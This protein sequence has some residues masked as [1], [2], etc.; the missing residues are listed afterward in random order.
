M[1]V[2]AVA[3]QPTA[4]AALPAV[5]PLPSPSASVSGSPTAI[6][7]AKPLPL[8]LGPPAPTVGPKPLPT[9]TPSI[10]PLP[11]PLPPERPT[12]L[13]AKPGTFTKAAPTYKITFAARWCPTYEDIRANK[14][15]NNIMESLQNLGPDTNYTS[16]EAVSV[17]KED[18]AP[19]SACTP[20]ADWLFQFGDGINGKTPGTNLSRVSNPGQTAST[21]SGV[22]E[23]DAMGNAT[24]RTIAGAVTVTLTQEQV[25]QANNHTLWIQGGTSGDP[26]GQ[27]TFP[28]QFG[29]GALRCAND[30]VNG[31]NVEFVSFTSSQRHVFCYYYS[32]KPPPAAGIIVIKKALSGI[33][34]SDVTFN[35][36]GNTSYNP[37]GAFSLKGGQSVEFVR[38]ATADTGFRWRVTEDIPADWRLAITCVSQGASRTELVGNNGVDIALVAGDKVTCTFTNAPNP[39]PNTLELG[40]FADGADGTFDYRVTSPSNTTI[41]SGRVSVR[42]G[43]ITRIG[44]YNITTTGT[45]KV[46]ET[47]PTSSNGTWA[48]TQVRCQ[49]ATG[50]VVN[51]TTASITVSALGARSGSYCVL[52]NTFT[53]NYGS[54]IIRSKTT[55]GAGG[56]TQYQI[57]DAAVDPGAVPTS[58]HQKANNVVAEV[59][60][61]AVPVTAADA[62]TRL[63]PGAYQIQGLG[64]AATGDASWSLSGLDCTG[65]ATSGLN[66]AEG[67]VTITVPARGN[68]VCDFTWAKAIPATLTLGK[69]EVLSGGARTSDVVIVAEC[70]NSAQA[71][72]TVTPSQAL[73]AFLPTPMTFTQNTRCVVRETSQG[74]NPADTTWQV[75]TP[76]GTLTGSGTTAVVSIKQAD[77]PGGAYQVVF[78][79]TYGAGIATPT[80]TATP[81]PSPSPTPSEPDGP[82][83]REV[84]VPVKPPALPEVIDPDSPTVIWPEDLP[85]NAGQNIKAV[86]Y[87]TTRIRLADAVRSLL[88]PMGDVRTC[89]VTRSKSGK[90]TLDV[91]APGP[92]RVFLV[93]FAPRTADYERYLAVRTWVTTP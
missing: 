72:L 64:P 42:D 8:P 34:S 76:S 54:L 71:A 30:N 36:G 75:V 40:K 46:V 27:A 1:T 86:V 19:Q 83:E 68:V 80:P 91:L 41:D 52:V 67:R 66:R 37:D 11:Q 70:D 21:T 15:R 59:F 7:S 77:F 78:T 43:T 50:T 47:V 31:D 84:Q 17:T 10:V 5:D 51:A 38:G 56:E 74:G 63:D 32:V 9:P 53:P 81:E 55:G 22:P 16:G 60:A 45:Y 6:A 39:P 69:A 87:C 20:F 14:A 28:G 65:G 12:T 18:A 93:Q 58:R 48:L 3:S 73:P 33:A 62:T 49:G 92:V 57:D 29:F 90:L 2:D 24:G 25:N 23:L 44:T 35:F 4:A 79:N 89:V 88:V 13:P 85:T 61:S 82:D 26:L